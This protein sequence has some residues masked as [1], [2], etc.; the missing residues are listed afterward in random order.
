MNE[1]TEKNTMH[2][3]IRKI[4]TLALMAAMSIM[5]LYLIRFPI[6]PAAPFLEY[7]PAN[8][9]IFIAT[10]LYGPFS[11]LAVTAVTCLIQGF[12][13]SS[14]SGVIGILMHFFAT[15]SFVL[16]AG[17]LFRKHKNGRRLVFASVSG[18]LAIVGMMVLWN[19]VFTPLFMGTP[20]EAVL[21]M[22]V[23]VIIPFNLIKAGVNVLIAAFVYKGIRKWAAK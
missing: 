1:L 17:F 8:I 7:D 14:S 11:G 21:Q 16:V 9:P 5:L 13:V 19:L 20:V 23:P 18:A 22:L 4:V 15:G 6:F 2:N 3:R 10:Y 12:T